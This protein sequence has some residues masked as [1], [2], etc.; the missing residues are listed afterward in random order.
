MKTYIPLTLRVILTLLFL[1]PAFMKLTANPMIVES[2][3]NFGYP[4]TFMYFIGAA[5]LLGALG[6]AFGQYINVKLP[7][8]AT[9]GLMIIM[10]GAVGSHIIFGDPLV[11]AIPAMVFFALLATYLRILKK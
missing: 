10:I 11:A 5:E 2:F 8:L 1:G 7:Q 4:M 9:A 3:S 6:I